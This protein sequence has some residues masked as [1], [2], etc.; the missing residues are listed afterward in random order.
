VKE[1]VWILPIVVSISFVLGGCRGVAL[2]EIARE[3]LKSFL[4]IVIGIFV[5]CVALQVVLW[6]ITVL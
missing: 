4:R 5:L 6:L 3:S 2:G 1:L